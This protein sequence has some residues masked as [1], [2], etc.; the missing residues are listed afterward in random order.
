MSD[1]LFTSVT[2]LLAFQKALSVTSNNVANVATP[3][4]S[5]ERANFSPQLGFT[6]SVGSFGKNCGEIG[7]L[8]TL[9]ITHHQPLR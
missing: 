6:T 8:T 5:V 1:V 9:H 3:G 7:G 4:Y 2:G